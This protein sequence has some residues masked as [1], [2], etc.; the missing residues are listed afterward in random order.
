MGYKHENNFTQDEAENEDL[1]F[2]L[3]IQYR[4]NTSWQGTINFLN[5]KKTCIFRS[6]LE[7]GNLLHEA[8]SK[9][10]G[11]IESKCPENKAWEDKDIVS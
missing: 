5:S 10:P 11:E 8:I 7:L 3:R 4:R 6:V 2:Y 9:P 1:V